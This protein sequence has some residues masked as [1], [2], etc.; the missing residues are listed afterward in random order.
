MVTCQPGFDLLTMGRASLDLY[1]NEA[2]APFTEIKSFAAR[3]GG[4]P[5]NIA[6]GPQ[7]VEAGRR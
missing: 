6:M 2:G 4:S 3:V 1:S 7:P 5:T